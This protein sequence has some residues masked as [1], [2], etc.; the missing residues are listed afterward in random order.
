IN[1]ARGGVVDEDALAVALKSGK[2]RGAAIDVFESEPLS[3]E[4]GQRFVGLDN[5]I[6]TAHIGGVTEESNVRVSAATA[7]NIL[8]VLEG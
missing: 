3:A 7:Q 5:I 6:L 2:L 1:T 4:A 8:R